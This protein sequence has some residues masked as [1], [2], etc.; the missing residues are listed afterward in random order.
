MQ[1]NG[2]ARYLVA[3]PS[4]MS[5]SRC[6]AEE[7]TDAEGVAAGDDAFDADSFASASA[8]AMSLE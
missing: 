3:R 7:H 5:F 1:A 4:C 8:M 2:P 6:E